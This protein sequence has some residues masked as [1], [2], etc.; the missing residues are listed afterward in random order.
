MRHSKLVVVVVPM[1]TA[2]AANVGNVL[3]LPTRFIVGYAEITNHC[4]SVFE[5]AWE[6]LIVASPSPTSWGGGGGG[7][8]GVDQAPSAA[9]TATVRQAQCVYCG[10]AS[11]VAKFHAEIR[12]HPRM[13]TCA[14]CDSSG[15]SP[16]AP[17]A[18]GSRTH[19]FGR[20]S[21]LPRL[22]CPSKGHARIY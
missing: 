2:A 6:S 18:S 3:R 9:G 1:M 7:S 13:V 4:A 17:R 20:G 21:D 22:L 15:R 8:G 10:L 16:H 19:N 11:S 5:D 12:Y 14:R